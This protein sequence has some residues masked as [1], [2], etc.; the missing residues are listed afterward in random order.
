MIPAPTA[1]MC[2]LLR[3]ESGSAAEREERTMLTASR[4][5]ASESIHGAGFEGHPTREWQETVEAI[6]KAP[7]PS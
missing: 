4:E 1:A 3:A 6:G 2:S 5:T 7:A